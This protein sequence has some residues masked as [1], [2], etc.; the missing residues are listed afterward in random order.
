MSFELIEAE[1]EIEVVFFKIRVVVG[2]AQRDYGEENSEFE[3]VLEGVYVEEDI[4]VLSKIF[5]ITTGV[6]LVSNAGQYPIEIAGAD[7]GSFRSMRALPGERGCGDREAAGARG[8]C[9]L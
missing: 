8:C 2:N 1:R 6:S 7:A 4:T 5:I 9:R 3:F